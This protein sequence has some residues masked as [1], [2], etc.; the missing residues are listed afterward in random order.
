MTN[1]EGT[2]TENAAA[3]AEQG[4]YVAPEKASSKKGASQKKGAPKAKKGAK[5]TKA[6]REAKAGKKA[7][8]AHTK[9]SSAPR[10]ESKGAKILEMIRAA[11]GSDPGR[12]RKSHGLAETFDPGLPLD[13]RQEARPQD[14]VH[15]D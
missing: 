10:A 15:E 3:V 9:D 13:R 8:P 2:I 6:K 1:A 14:R 12:D 5:D 11:Q 7:K 4:A